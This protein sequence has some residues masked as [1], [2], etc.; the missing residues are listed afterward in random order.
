M[1]N[2]YWN[3]FTNSW[4]EQKKNQILSAMLPHLHVMYFSFPGS[5]VQSVTNLSFCRWINNHTDIQIQTDK[6]I[7]ERNPAA[8]IILWWVYFYLFQ[9]FCVLSRVVSKGRCKE[10]WINIYAAAGPKSKSQ[11]LYFRPK[12]PIIGLGTIS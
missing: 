4:F 2:W 7:T 9:K 1:K 8:K 5:L 11:S 10:C 12:G 6:K 3:L